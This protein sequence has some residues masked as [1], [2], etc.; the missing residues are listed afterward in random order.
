MILLLLLG[1]MQSK[2]QLICETI[3]I[4]VIDVVSFIFY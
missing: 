1:N 4:R 3:K 2:K